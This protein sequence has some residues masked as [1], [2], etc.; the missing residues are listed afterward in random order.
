VDFRPSGEV[1]VD[2]GAGPRTVSPGM[3]VLDLTPGGGLVPESGPVD[4]SQLEQFPRCLTVRWSGPD[5]GVVEAIRAHMGVRLLY[6]DDAVGDLDLRDTR[7]ATVRLGGRH[8]HSARLPEAVETVLLD[9]P[10]PGL[11][12]EAVDDGRGLDLRLL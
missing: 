8:L 1:E 5:R 4:W 3:Q 6:W 12:L 10:S 7:L 2:F 11:H 9:Q